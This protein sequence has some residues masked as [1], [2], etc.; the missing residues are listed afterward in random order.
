METMLCPNP[1]CDKMKPSGSGSWFSN[2]CHICH[3]YRYVSVEEYHQ[4]I[5]SVD[6]RSEEDIAEDNETAMEIVKIIN[7]WEPDDGQDK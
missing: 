2:R 3:G 7:E 4:A 1:D 5:L 6:P